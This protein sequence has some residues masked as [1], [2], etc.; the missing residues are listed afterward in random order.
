VAVEVLA[1]FVEREA[2]LPLRVTLALTYYAVLSLF[3]ALI[4]LVG[5]VSFVMDPQTLVANLTAIIAQLGPSGAVQT[6]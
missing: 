3:P 6:L 5:L 4:A 2:H 1:E